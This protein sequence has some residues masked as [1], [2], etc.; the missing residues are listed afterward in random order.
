MGAYG[1]EDDTNVL[2][3]ITELDQEYLRIVGA[4]NGNPKNG[5]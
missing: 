5:N 1:Y 3:L 2:E 4:N